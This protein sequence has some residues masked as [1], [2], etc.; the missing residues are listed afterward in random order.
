MGKM[1]SVCLQCRFGS[2]KVNIQ[3]PER[4]NLKKLALQTKEF[5][6]DLSA[7]I[8]QKPIH[9][10]LSFNTEVFGQPNFTVNC[11]C[12]LNVDKNDCSKFNE[13]FGKNLR[14]KHFKNQAPAGRSNIEVIR[15][16]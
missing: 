13:A 10:S 7:T 5:T 3:V 11:S 4:Y 1:E 14:I 9:Y 2:V 15:A 16:H 12:I 6:A 8:K